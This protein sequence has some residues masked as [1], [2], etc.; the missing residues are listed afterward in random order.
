MKTGMDLVRRRNVICMVFCVC[1]I[2]LGSAVIL[3]SQ[4]NPASPAGGLEQKTNPEQDKTIRVA[5][6][7]IRIDA[8]VLNR[9]GRQITDLEAYDFEIYQDGKKQ[10]V[11]SCTYVNDY[12]PKL[13][14]KIPLV[15]SPAP[16]RDE[17]RR[18]VLFIVDDLSM[19]FELFYYTRMALANFVE[20]Q[21]QP[22][23][24]VGILPT[25]FGFGRLFSTDKRQLLSTIEK[26]QWGAYV[27]CGPGG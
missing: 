26:I 13:E 20:K 23:D 17:I 25:S 19:S 10:E 2:C 6:D 16:T 7:E 1:L 22:G 14:R 27:N 12:I 8:V 18:T 15:S 3:H 21:M 24:L 11:I 4:E 9:K 5:V